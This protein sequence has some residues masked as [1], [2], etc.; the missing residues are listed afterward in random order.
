MQ[1]EIDI[2]IEPAQ[3][4]SEVQRPEFYIVSRQKFVILYLTTYG[5]Y[6]VYWFYKNWACYKHKYRRTIHPVGRAIFSIF[7]VHELFNIVDARLKASDIAFQWFPGKFATIFIISRIIDNDTLGEIIGEFLVPLGVFS[8]SLTLFL[9]RFFILLRAQEA[10]NFSQHD[11]LGERN[12][13][14]TGTNYFWIIVG[15]LLFWSLPI[16]L[17]LTNLGLISL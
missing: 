5:A 10:I 4:K 17:L 1:K 2:Y 11:P 13:E 7:F 14:L 3:I 6:T 9:I 15:L 16:L 8:I 12:S